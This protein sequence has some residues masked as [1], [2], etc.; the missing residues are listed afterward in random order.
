MVYGSHRSRLNFITHPLKEGDEIECANVTW[1]I[2]EIP[3]H[4]LDHI[5]FFHQAVLFCGDTLFSVGCGKIFEG[6]PPEMYHSL[7]KLAALPHFTNLFCG[8]EY[9]LANLFFAKQV[10]PNNQF[11][12]EKLAN[13]NALLAKKLPTLP[14]LLQ[15][16]LLIN[17]FLRCHQKEIIHAVE[18]YA[19]KQLNDPVEVFAHL[20][21]W[22]N[23]FK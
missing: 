7:S 4:T 2:L 10:D 9:T 12:A 22:K 1:R 17:P 20:R 5:A 8:H 18:K 15:E 3:G 19:G 14:A 13:V 6:D 16:E 11:I 23:S 21:E